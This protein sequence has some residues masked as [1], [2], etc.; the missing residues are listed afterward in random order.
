MSSQEDVFRSPDIPSDLTITIIGLG[1]LGGSLAAA[2]SKHCRNC[3]VQAWARREE[4]IQQARQL[5]LIDKGSTNPA[6]V[7]PSSDISILCIPLDATLKFIE[8][9]ADLWCSESIVSDVGSV[10]EKIQTVAE[11][12]LTKRGVYFVGGH[13]IAGSEEGG[14]SNADSELFQ[15]ATVF[16]TPGE[17][18]PTFTVDRLSRLWRHLG[19]LPCALPAPLH[20]SIVAST[21]H[22]PHLV[23][24]MLA[25]QVLSDE[26]NRYGTG[27]AFRDMTRIA[28]SNSWMW[29]EI[30]S[31]NQSY[32]L[33]QL[34]DYIAKLQR[35]EELIKQNAWEELERHLR[36]AAQKHTHWQDWQN[37]RQ[38]PSVNDCERF[39]E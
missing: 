15:K 19:A 1:L 25:D 11:P 26:R 33:D 30:F 24:S 8:A 31:Y 4:S 12:I 7:L 35:I 6:D 10:K 27:G 2:L 14:L 34:H 22:L 36:N 16:L 37:E 32:L 20:D 28:S 39:L 38:N 3:H 21:S 13:P 9:N 23:S 5:A 29:R 17:T 18:T